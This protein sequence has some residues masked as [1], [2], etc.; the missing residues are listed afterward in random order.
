MIR[1]LEDLV[2]RIMFFVL[3]NY[4]WI[5]ISKIVF[6]VGGYI[7]RGMWLAISS[8]LFFIFVWNCNC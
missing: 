3:S 6:F 8:F 7:W 1:N 4:V 2:T 5:L